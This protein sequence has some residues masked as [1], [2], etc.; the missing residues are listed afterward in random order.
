MFFRRGAMFG[1]DARIA[2]A[3][4]GALSVISGAA[5]YSAI[6]QAKVVSLVTQFQE[7]AK[8]RE[9]FM[10]DTG[11]DLSLVGSRNLKTA[12]LVTKTGSGWKGPYV[13]DDVYTT[14][15]N[16]LKTSRY[17]QWM[18][19]LAPKTPAWNIPTDLT[20][21]CAANTSEVCYIWIHMLGITQNFNEQIDLYI[22]GEVN[23]QEG[24]YRWRSNA[25]YYNVGLA[26]N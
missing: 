14:D 13:S 9:Q 26:F 12:E 20:P 6:Q 22:D 23:A 18:F 11:Q 3:I 8:A 5:L 2:L 21:T 25:T 24:N 1:L 10:L 7:Y 17:A 4:F 19:V 16:Y 15:T